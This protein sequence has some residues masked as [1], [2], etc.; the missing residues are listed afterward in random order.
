M[1]ADRGFNGRHERLA[2]GGV[3]LASPIYK[4]TK[5]GKAELIV[6]DWVKGS[7]DLQDDTFPGYWLRYTGRGDKTAV[8]NRQRPLTVQG[9]ATHTLAPEDALLHAAIHLAINHQFD[10]TALRNMVDM[11]R[12]AHVVGADWAVVAERARAWRVSTVWQF[13]AGLMAQ[14]WGED[15]LPHTPLPAWRARLLGRFITPAHLLNQNRLKYGPKRFLLLLALAHARHG[16][17]QPVGHLRRA[18]Q[19]GQSGRAGVGDWL[20]LGHGRVCRSLSPPPLAWRG[21]A[22]ALRLGG[23]R[24]RANRNPVDL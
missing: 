1:G 17:R 18:T 24:P 15:A 9:Q 10:D 5:Y 3:Y 22:P 11:M 13:V 8:W 4:L 7:V 12:L 14:L 2:R 23:H 21:V 6:R 16:R 19:F 20:L